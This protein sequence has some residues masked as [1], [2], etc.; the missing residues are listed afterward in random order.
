MGQEPQG[1]GNEL[2]QSEMFGRIDTGRDFSGRSRCDSF[3]R[4]IFPLPP[5]S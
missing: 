4:S 1:G 2:D 3:R 5:I